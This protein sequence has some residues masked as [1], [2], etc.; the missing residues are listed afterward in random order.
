MGVSVS[1][2]HKLPPADFS[3]IESRN[4]IADSRKFERAAGWNSQYSI[5]DKKHSVCLDFHIGRCEGP[6]EG[7]VDTK[8]YNDMI[9]N[10]QN[11]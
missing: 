8:T 11:L 10:N 6:C 7:L 1:I 9:K 5:K 3:P 2:E 4:F